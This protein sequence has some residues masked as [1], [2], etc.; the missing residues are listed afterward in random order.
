MANEDDLSLDDFNVDDNP[1]VE[2]NWKED[3]GEEK[4]EQKLSV[5]GICLVCDETVA[6]PFKGSDLIPVVLCSRCKKKLRDLIL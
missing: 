1:F 5:K 6:L 4:E 2:E 3:F